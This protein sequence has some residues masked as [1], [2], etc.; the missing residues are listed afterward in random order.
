[1]LKRILL[2]AVLAGAV[3]ACD[4][5]GPDCTQPTVGERASW[6]ALY[7]DRNDPIDGMAIRYLT[8]LALEDCEIAWTG[9]PLD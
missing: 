8:N 6:H 3:S 2:L 5:A 4:H 1:M 9:G 7:L